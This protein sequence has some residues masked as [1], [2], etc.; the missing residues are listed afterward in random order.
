MAYQP[1]GLQSSLYCDCRLWGREGFTTQ[2]SKLLFVFRFLLR[3]IAGLRLAFGVYL[4][5]LWVPTWANPGDVPS[6]NKH[7]SD[8][9]REAIPRIFHTRRLLQENAA[10]CEELALF[11][12]YRSENAQFEEQLDTKFSVSLG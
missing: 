10:P 8:W 11:D 9:R 4:E 1:W 12:Q 3:Q 6:R 7:V 5:I 2:T